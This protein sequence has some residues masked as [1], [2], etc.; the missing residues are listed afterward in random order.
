M[1]V[2]CNVYGYTSGALVILFVVSEFLGAMNKI[3]VNG[4]FHFLYLVAKRFIA[5]P[6]MNR[7]TIVDSFVEAFIDDVENK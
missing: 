2:N 5:K 4:I 3:P 7:E 6:A 1:D